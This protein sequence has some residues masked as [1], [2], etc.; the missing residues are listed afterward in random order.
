M[1]IASAEDDQELKRLYEVHALAAMRASTAL[2]KEGTQSS[3]F[4]EADKLA[5]KAWRR[6][7]ILLGDPESY[8]T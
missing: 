8:W 3:K 1:K 7:R 2:A 6:I 4:K 5:G